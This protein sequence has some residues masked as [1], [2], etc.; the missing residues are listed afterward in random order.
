MKARRSPNRWPPPTMDRCI[1][2]PISCNAAARNRSDYTPTQ[3]V[4]VLNNY[5]TSPST[6]TDNFY[7]ISNLIIILSIQGC[8]MYTLSLF[9]S[10]NLSLNPFVY[11]VSQIRFYC[12]ITRRRSMISRLRERLF[13]ALNRAR[14]SLRHEYV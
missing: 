9:T 6:S 5:F 13:D 3:P 10:L 7:A 11:Q 2:R 8:L 14:C 1:Y 12:S 4:K